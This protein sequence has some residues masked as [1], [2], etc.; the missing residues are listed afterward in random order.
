VRSDPRWEEI[1]PDPI[2]ASTEPESMISRRSEPWSGRTT[3][4]VISWGTMD[5]AV[6]EAEACCK[7]NS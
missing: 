5:L 4:V 3:F 1:G 7:A 6:I 2:T